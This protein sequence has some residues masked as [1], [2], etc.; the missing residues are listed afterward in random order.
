[1]AS[2]CEGSSQPEILEGSGSQFKKRTVDR[3]TTRQPGRDWAPDLP[4]FR[5]RGRSV[6]DALLRILCRLQEAHGWSYATEAGLRKMVAEDTATKPGQD[7]VRRALDRLAAQGLL[8]QVWLLKGGLMPSG[9]VCT[10]GVRLVR[11]ALSR[12]ER[13]S[14]LYRA[15][16]KR[17][18]TTGRVNHRALFELM[19]AKGKLAPA[20]APPDAA[21]VFEERRRAALEAA[22]ELARRFAL[23][24]APS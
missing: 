22:Q 13:S 2:P 21:R 20:P 4:G 5:E 24:D 14:F 19:T 9:K 17:E 12:A 3:P 18:K 15:R 23:E 10:A 16:G 8:H 7:T 6:D 11:V 1:M